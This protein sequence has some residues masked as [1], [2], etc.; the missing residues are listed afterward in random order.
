MTFLNPGLLWGLLA[1]AVP[2]II[3]FFNLQRPRQILFSNVA[4]VKEV[5]RTVVKRVKFKQWLLLL[6]RLLAISCLVFAFANP[7]L[8]SGNQALLKGNRSVSIVVD[9]SYSMQAGNEKGEYF[10][11]ALSIAKRIS[12]AYSQQDELLFMTTSQ[13][14]RNYNFIEKQEA[15]DLINEARIKQN[16]L[17]HYE[18]LGATGEIFSKSNF[19]NKELFFIS[20]FQRS[21][22]LPDSQI[23][24][25]PDTNISISYI[26]IATRN[27][28]NAYVSSHKFVSQI[29]EED[30]PVQLEMKVVNDGNTDLNDLNIRIMLNDQAVAIDNQEIDAKSEKFVNLSFTPIESGWQSGYIAIDDYPID[31]DN[32]RYFSLYVPEKEKILVIENESSS[33]LKILYDQLFN[34]FDVNFV[35]IRSLGSVNFSDYRS[36]IFIGLSEVSSGLTDRIQTFLQEGG[37]VMV[38]PSKNPDLSSLNQFYQ[39]IN[40]GSIQAPISAPDGIPAAKVNLGH[41]V[42]KGIFSESQSNAEFDPPKVFKYYPIKL[43]N[44]VIHDKILSLANDEAMMVKSSIENGVVF[45]FSVFPDDSWTDFHVKTIFAPILYRAT[46]IMNQTQ[47]VQ[48]SQLIGLY[49]QY[50]VRSP[51]NELITLRSGENE[52]IPEQFNRNGSI[53]LLFNKLSIKEGNYQVLQEDSLLEHISFNIPDQESQLEF[54]DQQGLQEVLQR[55]NYKGIDVLDALPDRLAADIQIAKEGFPIWKYLIWLGILF[56]LVEVLLLRFKTS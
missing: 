55:N 17:P 25:V 23:T 40:L 45:S 31:F 12:Q 19:A 22:A 35:N 13:L 49:E 38:F 41:P 20:D 56:L 30:K 36:L 51:K 16:I 3:H 1:L 53:Q 21:T 9:N 54:A 39:Q 4:F 5:K 14:K 8:T 29:I 10:Q 44:R 26:P 48:S 11:Q 34:T 2:I 42:F 27:Q 33:N 24:Y 28:A 47:R 46:Q 52:M 43:D 32:Q 15:L 7:I 6:A 18:I 50:A 37:G